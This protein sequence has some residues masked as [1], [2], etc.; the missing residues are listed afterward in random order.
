MVFH[1]GQYQ[2]S[3]NR[4][5]ASATTVKPAPEKVESPSEEPLGTNTKP[6]YQNL[7]MAKM[8]ST[9]LQNR[10]L[11]V[12]GTGQR[13]DVLKPD[14]GHRV[15]PVLGTVNATNKDPLPDK[16]GLKPTLEVIENE[17]D[18]FTINHHTDEIVNMT[19]A[20]NNATVQRVTISQTAQVLKLIFRFP[21]DNHDYYNSTLTV[22][23]VLGQK[24]W[25]N[26]SD[27]KNVRVSELL[28]A[29]HRLAATV[30]LNFDFPFYGHLV[31][32][33]TIATGGF[34]YTGEYVHS[35][36]AATQYIAPLM[37]NFDTRL[38]NESIIKYVDNGTAFTVQWE[39]VQL[40]DKRDGG[41]FTFQATLHKSG[42]IV[43]VY[44]HVPVNIDDVGDEHHPVKVGL[45]DAY[46]IDRTIFC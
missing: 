33:V 44:K 7:E 43:F 10:N 11:G 9:L 26:M 2:H 31:P 5:S 16:N 18:E 29:S 21:Q 17:K 45:S 25:V 4:R 37:A 15:P 46:I 35:W 19:A 39:R 14:A 40:Q 23:P 3:I 34:L 27:N 36:L 38:S 6:A 13:K 20:E 24:Y 30:Q 32:N 28:S 22:D 1:D 12:N 41:E 42:D 8:N